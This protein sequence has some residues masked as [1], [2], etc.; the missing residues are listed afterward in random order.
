MFDDPDS[1]DEL[2]SRQMRTFVDQA[3]HAH[4]SAWPRI[5]RSLSS[6]LRRPRRRLS[7]WWILPGVM[8]P[9]AATVVTAAALYSHTAPIEWIFHQP[10]SASSSVAGNSYV[11]PARSLSLSQAE[12][13]L[14]V[15]LVQ[16][17]G[18]AAISLQSVTFQGATTTSAHVT[19]PSRKGIVTLTYLL[20]GR[21]V[22]LREYN[23]GPGP[24]VSR[25]RPSSGSDSGGTTIAVMTIHHGS[26][27]VE[28]NS[29]GGV[30]F[31]EWK[32]LRDV[33]VVLNGEPNR[34]LSLTFVRS[35]VAGAR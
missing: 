8:L 12:S 26:Y 11:P 16:L 21:K 4:E 5:H 34:P 14:G 31:V 19:A 32:T 7:R 25:L 30:L 6:R 29:H 13:L 3:S 27:Q 20:R 22:S 35:I 28:R 9:L 15:R 10:Q 1:F 24:I 18:F 23:S 33:L 2:L 17:R